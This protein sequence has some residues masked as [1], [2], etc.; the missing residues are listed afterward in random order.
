MD[1]TQEY[2]NQTQIYVFK[3][4]VKKLHRSNSD[5]LHSANR[6]STAISLDKTLASEDAKGSIKGNP[7]EV[8]EIDLGKIKV[9]QKVDALLKISYQNLIL[10]TEDAEKK[11]NSR[12]ETMTKRSFSNGKVS[13]C[14]QK[15]KIPERGEDHGRQK[16]TAKKPRDLADVLSSFPIFGE[17]Q[18][19]ADNK[20][21]LR[22]LEIK[23]L[24]MRSLERVERLHLTKAEVHSFRIFPLQPDKSDKMKKLF[25]LIKL[26][27][28]E[29]VRRILKAG[30]DRSQE[31]MN[32]CNHNLEYMS[33]MYQ[34]EAFDKSIIDDRYLVYH[35]DHM[36][37]TPLHWA[38]KE[39]NQKM[40]EM[41]LGERSDEVE[42]QIKW[43]SDPNQEDFFRRTPLF[44]AV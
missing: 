3:D 7:E 5:F 19:K 20:K 35:M 4:V 14:H 39:Q 44:L 31:F 40:V 9:T 18:Y 15:E 41:L 13:F 2:G 43:R 30:Y 33:Y 1:P 28:V 12:R 32:K 42:A 37:L 34:Q 21:R 16:P 23:K 38:V 11:L 24:I 36:G 17:L 29:A 25:N 10:G 27:D 6:S 8:Y 22:Q 26:G